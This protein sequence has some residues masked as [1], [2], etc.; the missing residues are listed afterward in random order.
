MSPAVSQMTWC[1]TA[2]A[3]YCVYNRRLFRDLPQTWRPQHFLVKMA[4]R[5][6]QKLVVP[7]S[8]AIGANHLSLRRR[9]LHCLALLLVEALAPKRESHFLVDLLVVE[10]ANHFAQRTC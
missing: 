8:F 4:A 10:D 5:I 9:E 3:E 1:E 6:L 2:D 7:P